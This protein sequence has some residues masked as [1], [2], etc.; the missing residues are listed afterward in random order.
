MDAGPAKEGKSVEGTGNLTDEKLEK[1]SEQIVSEIFKEV[2][3]K[4]KSDEEGSEVSEATIE[5][6]N[7]VLLEQT[8]ALSYFDGLK[9][10]P[11]QT[12]EEIQTKDG[13]IKRSTQL[14]EFTESPKN[15]LFDDPPIFQKT[16]SKDTENSEYSVD[17]IEGY[18][19]NDVR[20]PSPTSSATLVASSAQT[21]P[22][23]VPSSPL[24]ILHPSPP[25]LATSKPLNNTKLAQAAYETSL[26]SPIPEFSPQHNKVN[27]KNTLFESN[28]QTSLK[29]MPCVN[30]ITTHDYGEMFSFFYEIPQQIIWLKAR[31]LTQYDTKDPFYHHILTNCS[32]L[33]PSGWEW[34]NRFTVDSNVFYKNKKENRP[35]IKTANVRGLIGSDIC[36]ETQ[37]IEI[38]RDV[39]IE[40]FTLLLFS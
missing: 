18:L 4:K 27:F 39:P 37:L 22:T 19:F 6:S 26:T 20:P 31:I 17:S 13:V 1:L 40:R 12:S 15:I 33:R 38:T 25:T 10:V 32:E 11:I 16:N 24:T 5:P 34:L 23:L 14:E 35:S 28:R 9:W 21:S 8:C 7:Q 29:D 2:L 36:T 30:Q 3:K